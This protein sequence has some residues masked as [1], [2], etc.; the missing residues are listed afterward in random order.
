MS[1]ELFDKNGDS[2]LFHV[3]R[4]QGALDS[5]AYFLTKEEAVSFD[6]VDTNSTGKISAKEVRAAAKE[7]GIEN[8]QKEKIA[9]LKEQLG[10][11]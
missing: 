2:Q 3:K 10:L 4:F 6:K 7:A 8:Y 1:V 5:G 9:V 11:S